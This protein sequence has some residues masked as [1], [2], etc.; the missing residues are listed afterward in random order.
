LQ[1]VEF[2]IARQIVTLLTDANAASAKLRH[3]SRHQLFPPV[4]RVVHRYVSTKVNFRGEHPCELGLAKYVDRLVERLS[5]AIE[6]DDT[7]G[8]PPLIPV[9]NRYQPWGSSRGVNFK[10]KRPCH[11]TMKSHVNQV[12]LDTER[13]ESSAAFRL[14][15]SKHVACYV[16]NDHMGFVIPYEF[17]GVTHSFEPDFLVRL[18]DKR[19]LIVEV[20]G[21]EDEQTRAKH[22]AAKRWVSAV[23]R[24]GRLGRWRFVVCKDPQ[25]LE[26][27]VEHFAGEEW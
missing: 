21:Y 25:L 1:Q 4:L 9:L 19:M 13:W 23:N 11:W 10:T 12:V 8:E 26:R 24:V 22:Q 20:K 5:Q 18:T 7:A 17:Q 2:E 3:Q 6:P 15:Q 27:Q 14:E 16:R